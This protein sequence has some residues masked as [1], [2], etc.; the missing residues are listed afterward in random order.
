MN[1]LPSTSKTRQPSARAM[2]GGVPPTEPK[3]RTGLFTPPGIERRARRNSFL[4]FSVFILD[5]ARRKRR[6]DSHAVA[7]GR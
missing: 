3:A 5:S 4:D 2:K 1:E 6:V 7:V